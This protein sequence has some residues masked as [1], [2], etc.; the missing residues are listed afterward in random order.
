MAVIQSSVPE[1]LG[2]WIS[3]V[4]QTLQFVDT[5]HAFVYIFVEKEAD[6]VHSLNYK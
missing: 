6:R 3:L 1:P 4:S 5:V 2:E